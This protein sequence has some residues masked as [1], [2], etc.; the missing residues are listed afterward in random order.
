[1]KLILAI[2]AVASLS[3]CATGPMSDADRDRALHFLSQRPLFAAPDVY[4]DPA[5]YNPNRRQ[6]RCVSRQVGYQVVTQC[7]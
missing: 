5:Q 4:Y 1:M 2:L 7:N 3:A 6:I